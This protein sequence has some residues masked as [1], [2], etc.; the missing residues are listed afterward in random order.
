MCEFVGFAGSSGES[1]VEAL[2]VAL[3]SKAVWDFAVGGMSCREGH[4]EPPSQTKPGQAATPSPGM[5][6]W[7]DIPWL[8]NIWTP[9]YSASHLRVRALSESPMARTTVSA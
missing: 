1:L 5:R 9:T 7:P 4:V 8:R 3:L 6:P 2:L